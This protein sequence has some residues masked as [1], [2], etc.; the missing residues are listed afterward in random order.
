MEAGEQ[1]EQDQPVEDPQRID[2]IAQTLQALKDELSTVK[3]EL[4]ELKI[5][6]S[7][8]VPLLRR[9]SP[10]IPQRHRQLGPLVQLKVQ[11]LQNSVLPRLTRNI[12]LLKT[13]I[14]LED[15]LNLSKLTLRKTI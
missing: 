6:T 2:S 8:L 14:S 4:I 15:C 7:R 12:L 11:I 9:D 3:T 5:L 1:Q 10:L 13:V